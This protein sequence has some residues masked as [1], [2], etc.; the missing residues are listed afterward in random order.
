MIKNDFMNLVRWCLTFEKFDGY[1]SIFISDAVFLKVKASL[2]QEKIRDGAILL[3]SLLLI[4]S[5]KREHYQ[6][7]TRCL[8]TPVHNKSLKALGFMSICY[9]FPVIFYTYEAWFCCCL[10]FCVNNVQYIYIYIY[11]YEFVLL[12]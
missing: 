10:F 4:P 2:L 7:I 3:P 6:T 1:F 11:I 12:L 9:I 5:L 8:F